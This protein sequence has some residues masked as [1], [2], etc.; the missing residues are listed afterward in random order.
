[1]CGFNCCRLFDWEKHKIL[2]TMGAFTGMVLFRRMTG[3]WM[4]ICLL[5]LC[6]GAVRFADFQGH[7]QY[8]DVSSSL[9]TGDII[10]LGTKTLRGMFVR[11]T[12]STTSYA[13]VGIVECNDKGCFLLHADPHDGCIAESLKSFFS[14]NEVSVLAVLRPSVP[15]QVVHQAVDFAK[16]CINRHVPF[17]HSLKYGSGTGVYCTEFVIMAYEKAQCPLLDNVVQGGLIRPEKLLKSASLE[18]VDI[19]YAGNDSTQI[20]AD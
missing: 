2:K 1:M 6:L 8:T 3:R 13:H 17:N 11:M 18:I 16:E 12:N 19:Q 10:L 15:K 20:C 7:I 9:Q 4:A 14:Q 5:L